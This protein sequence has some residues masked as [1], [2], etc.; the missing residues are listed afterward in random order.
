MYRIATFMVVMMFVATTF[1]ISQ[2]EEDESLPPPKRAGSVKIGG[3]VGFTQSLLF[4]NVDPI[5]Q[6]LRAQNLAEFSKDGLLMLGGQ[7]YAYVI[8]VPNL[9]I[10]YQSMGGRLKS[11]T[12]YQASNTVREVELAVGYSAGTVDYTIPILARIDVTAGIMLGGGEMD[13]KFARSYGHGQDWTSTWAEFGG[14]QAAEEYSGK[15]SGSF[16]VYQPSVNLEFAVFR[17]LGI[18]AGVSYLGMAGGDWKRDDKYDV[19]G[20]PDDVSGKGW[21]IHSGIFLGTFVF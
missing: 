3:A 12:L 7:G 13:L 21:M 6:V 9:R 14:D 5:N 18:R 4:V 8:L 17:W 11:K 10:G 2:E 1:V 19:Y 16:F 20:V 15:I